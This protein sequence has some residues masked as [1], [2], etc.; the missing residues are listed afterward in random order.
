ME[1]RCLHREDDGILEN[2]SLAFTEHYRECIPW[3]FS[4]PVV[5]ICNSRIMD[6]KNRAHICKHT[7]FDVQKRVKM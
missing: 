7:V 1:Y 6:A 4:H 2:S 5:K 3:I